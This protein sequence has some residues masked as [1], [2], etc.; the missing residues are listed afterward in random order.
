MKDSCI[1]ELATWR[2]KV[3]P[4]QCYLEFFEVIANSDMD[5]YYMQAINTTYVNSP[6]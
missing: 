6:I 4:F 3:K 1:N 2:A 5:K